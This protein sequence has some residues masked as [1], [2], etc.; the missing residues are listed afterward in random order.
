MTVKMPDSIELAGAHVRL[1]PLAFDHVPDLFLAGGG[2]EEVWQWMLMPTPGTEDELRAAAAILIR[3]RESGECVP[4]AV[5]SRESGRAVGWTSFIDVP[6]FDESIE[7]GW[8]WYARE[9][10]RTAINTE[11]KSL[12]LTH[13]FE[14]AG[15]NRVQFKTDNL[16]LRSQRAIAR[17]GGVLEGTLRRHKIR[18]DGTWRDSVVFSILDDEWPGTKARITDRLARGVRN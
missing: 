5:V 2:D 4:F 16:N 13:A 14:V 15:Y 1:E 11:S 8:T 17:I 6:T 9:A 3:H 18:P 7:I 12:L 10:R